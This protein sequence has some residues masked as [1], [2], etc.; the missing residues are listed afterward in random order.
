MSYS[1][2]LCDA[3][4]KYGLKLTIIAEKVEDLTGTRPRINYFSKFQNVKTSPAGD[5]LNTA[6][7]MGLETNPIEL[8][9]ES[10]QG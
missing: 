2:I 7:A 10:Y 9:T 5:I 1:K 6:L 8:K 4:T 3:I